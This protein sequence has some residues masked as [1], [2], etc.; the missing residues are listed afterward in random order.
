MVTSKFYRQQPREEEG[1]V[2]VVAKDSNQ[3][4]LHSLVMKRHHH[5]QVVVVVM[6]TE[7]KFFYHINQLASFNGYE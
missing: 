5:H 4:K 6:K 3:H 2:E 7:L 1:R